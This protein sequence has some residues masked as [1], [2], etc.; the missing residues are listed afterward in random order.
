MTRAYSTT[1]IENKRN[2]PNNTRYSQTKID[3][4]INETYD[5]SQSQISYNNLDLSMIENN[6]GK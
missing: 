1:F 5:L 3:D 2:N 6:S 4:L